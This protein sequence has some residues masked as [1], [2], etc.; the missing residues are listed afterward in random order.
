[1]FV[2]VLVPE[3]ADSAVFDVAVL[4]EADHPLLCFEIGGL[5]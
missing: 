1:V 5:D 3:D 2:I 4:V